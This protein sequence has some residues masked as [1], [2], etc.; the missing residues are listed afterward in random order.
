MAKLNIVFKN[1]F[2]LIK[3]NINKLLNKGKRELL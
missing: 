3:E 1:M 2:K